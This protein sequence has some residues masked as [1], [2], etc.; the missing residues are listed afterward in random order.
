MLCDLLWGHARRPHVLLCCFGGSTYSSW[1]RDKISSSE[2]P[3]RPLGKPRVSKGSEMGGAL[4]TEAS[5]KLPRGTWDL[6]LLLRFGGGGM[7]IKEPR[8]EQKELYVL[9][10]STRPQCGVRGSEKF[11]SKASTL[12]SAIRSVVL[13]RSKNDPPWPK[14]SRYEDV[15]TFSKNCLTDCLARTFSAIASTAAPPAQGR[16]HGP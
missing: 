8:S 11:H 9:S 10:K 16:K 4:I 2:R 13:G 1:L 7:A 3:P 15:L 12:E 5:S 6:F 14:W